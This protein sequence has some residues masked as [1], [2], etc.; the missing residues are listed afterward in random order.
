MHG[1]VINLAYSGSVQECG[2]HQETTRSRA[3]E[4]EEEPAECAPNNYNISRL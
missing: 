4:E 1:C 2:Q 3:F